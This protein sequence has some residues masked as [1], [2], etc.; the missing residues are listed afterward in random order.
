[1]SS[2]ELDWSDCRISVQP[3]SWNH[4][5]SAFRV[6]RAR[7]HDLVCNT[8]NVTAFVSNPVKSW[9]RQ[10]PSH[11]ESSAFRKSVGFGQTDSWVVSSSPRRL[12]PRGES[13]GH[14]QC[15]TTSRDAGRAGARLRS[16]C[17]FTGAVPAQ[18]HSRSSDWPARRTWR[19]RGNV[20]LPGA[21]L[22]DNQEFPYGLLPASRRVSTTGQFRHNVPPFALLPDP[23]ESNR[24][25]TPR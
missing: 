16:P 8:T 23:E 1:M 10:G 4:V 3:S 15:A 18:C 9:A 21:C 13:P 14:S 25:G 7:C 22:S 20:S 24:D 11:N 12:F 19:T 17:R 2:P 5:T 6:G